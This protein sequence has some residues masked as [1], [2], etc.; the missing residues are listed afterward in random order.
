MQTSDWLG[1]SSLFMFICILKN[2]SLKRSKKSLLVS[3]AVRVSSSKVILYTISIPM[4]VFLVNYLKKCCIS[5]DG[6]RFRLWFK[7]Y[8]SNQIHFLFSASSKISWISLIPGQHQHLQNQASQGLK[9]FMSI[10]T[11]R[12]LIAK[13][14][15]DLSH[16]C[17]LKIQNIYLLA[18]HM[19]CETTRTA[20]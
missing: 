5:Y 3:C 15:C 10:Q 1:H 11:D 12:W 16:F 4:A 9:T 18:I 13:L 20:Y 17:S 7:S 19:C 6:C 8:Q 2:Y 14:I